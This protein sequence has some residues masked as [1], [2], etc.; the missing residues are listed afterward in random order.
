[1]VL[2]KKEDANPKNARNAQKQEPCRRRKKKNLP[3]A[4][5]PAKNNFQ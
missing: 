2:Q 4:I 1:V 5:A 3:A